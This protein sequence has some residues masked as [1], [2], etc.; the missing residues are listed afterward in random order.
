[1]F[2]YVIVSA[3]PFLNV[4]VALIIAVFMLTE[5]FKNVYDK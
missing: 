4:I 2:L 5:K 3:M 1:L